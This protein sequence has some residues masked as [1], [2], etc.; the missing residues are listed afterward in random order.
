ML[1]RMRVVGFD[2]G[3]GGSVAF[4]TRA[5]AILAQHCRFE[6]GFGTNPEGYANLLRAGGAV[7]ARFET[8][9]RWSR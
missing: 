2:C 4:Y 3:A 1:R 8:I 9:Q 5:C 6:S 7:A